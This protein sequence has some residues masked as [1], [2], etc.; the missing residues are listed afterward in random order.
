MQL[1]TLNMKLKLKKTKLNRGLFLQFEW[2]YV[3]LESDSTERWPV[4]SILS[5]EARAELSPT[6]PGSIVE[7]TIV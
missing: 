4:G 3:V 1:T 5:T 6:E 2:V 7:I